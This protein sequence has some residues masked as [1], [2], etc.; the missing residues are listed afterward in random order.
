MP[1]PEHEHAKGARH[2]ARKHPAP[3]ARPVLAVRATA[4]LAARWSGEDG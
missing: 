1:T 3:E 4:A 2:I